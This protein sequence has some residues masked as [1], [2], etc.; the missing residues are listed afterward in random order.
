MYR[1]DTLLMRWRKRWYL[2]NSQH[3]ET[4]VTEGSPWQLR[5]R[6]DLIRPCDFNCPIKSIFCTEEH[7]DTRT[8]LHQ[9]FYFH[10]NLWRNRFTRLSTKPTFAIQRAPWHSRSHQH[11]TMHFTS[12]PEPQGPDGRL[13]FDIW[14]LLSS[15]CF[16]DNLSNRAVYA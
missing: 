4:T 13:P 7:L 2:T 15:F 8:W 5:P 1:M 16:F 12:S 11:S 3:V 9:T 10:P 14:Q 6:W